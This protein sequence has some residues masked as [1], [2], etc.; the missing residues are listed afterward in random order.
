M[1]TSNIKGTP[2][3]HAIT[4]LSILSS[5]TLFNNNSPLFLHRGGGGSRPTNN[6]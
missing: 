5:Q 6:Q 3:N 4:Y 2:N 1:I